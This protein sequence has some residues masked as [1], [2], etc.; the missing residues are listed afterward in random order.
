[1]RG[2]VDERAR[3]AHPLLFASG[4]VRGQMLGPLS[5]SHPLQRFHRLALVGHA[6]EVLRQHYVLERRQVGNQV[7]LLEHEADGLGAE[8][9]QF[10]VGERGHILA[11]EINPARAG[12]VQAADQVHQRGLPGAGRAHH[13]QPLAA[14]D[15]QRHI[16]Q[17]A[18]DARRWRPPARDTAG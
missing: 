17:R 12:A 15:V 7:K 18:Y 5:Q 8:A 16:V 3:D 4:K 14:L 11:F 13:R 10:G 6:V 2:I 9:V 1:M